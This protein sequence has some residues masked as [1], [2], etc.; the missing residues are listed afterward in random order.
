MH[1]SLFVCSYVVRS[2]LGIILPG[3]QVEVSVLLNYEKARKEGVDLST[4]RDRFQVLGI[5]VENPSSPE[6]LVKLWQNTPK[7]KVFETIV[8]CKF[9]PPSMVRTIDASEKSA[10][11][12]GVNNGG[13]AMNSPQT[14]ALMFSPQPDMEQAKTVFKSE[15]AVSKLK[16]EVKALKEDK[17][18]LELQIVE[19][20]DR[21]DTLT[22][23]V[24]ELRRKK[25]DGGGRGIGSAFLYVLLYLV[26][27]VLFFVVSYKAFGY[28]PLVSIYPEYSMKNLER[29]YFGNK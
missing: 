23:E 12:G 21:I 19:K 28:D 24:A 10:K 25:G 5:P 4:V 2:H 16:K 20:D 26:V 11:M 14:P 1:R 6:E 22:K 17:E 9:V 18:A 8:K 15:M 29:Q 3:R 27:L 7:E 13:N